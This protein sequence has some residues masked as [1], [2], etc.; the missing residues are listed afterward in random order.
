MEQYCG[1]EDIYR[2]LVLG[3]GDNWLSGLLAFAVVEEQRVA[4][5]KHRTN[6]TGT[7]PT[8]ADV[9]EWYQSQPASALM[10]AKAEADLA[11]N[12]FGSQS[13]E[14]FDDAYRREIAQG[15][16][17]SEVRKLGR[18]LPQFGMNVASGVI[19][20]FVFS[21]IL[22]ALA[23]FLMKASSTND[24]AMEFKQHMKSLNG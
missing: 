12:D 6:F 16:I 2:V 23:L 3:A 15:V 4:W 19:S 18:W 10:K 17:V 22:V 14:E 8:S 9:R 11:L 1:S 20:S 21:I 24:F 5:M 7:M 13:I